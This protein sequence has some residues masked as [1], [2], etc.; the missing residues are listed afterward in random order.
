M[1][2]RPIL[3]FQDMINYLKEEKKRLQEE[4]TQLKVIQDLD[5]KRM[6]E[7]LQNLLNSYGERSRFA[8]SWVE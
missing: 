2:Y 8:H 3:P 6:E 7:K 5:M 4:N 1:N